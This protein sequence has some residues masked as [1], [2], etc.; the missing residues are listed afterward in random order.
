NGAD[1]ACI[2][3]ALLTMIPDHNHLTQSGKGRDLGKRD[4]AVSKSWNLVS[5]RGAMT[6]NSLTQRRRPGET[7]QLLPKSWNLVRV[8]A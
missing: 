8:S 6:P 5:G 1:A 3:D 4:V 2:D 7:P